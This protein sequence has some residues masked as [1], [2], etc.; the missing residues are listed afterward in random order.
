MEYLKRISARQADHD[1]PTDLATRDSQLTAITRWGIPD[2]SKLSRLAA[3][4]QPTFVANG[5]NDTLMIIENSTCSPISCRTASCG[6][7]PTRATASS[8]N[9]P[10]CLPIRS[11]RF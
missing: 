9:T 7:T 1:E 5:D 4:T 3:M 11:P 2:P 10:P 6:S 8:I